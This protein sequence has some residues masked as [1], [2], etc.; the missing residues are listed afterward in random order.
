MAATRLAGATARAAGCD[1]KSIV[2]VSRV[3]QSITVSATCPARTIFTG[4]AGKK[5]ALVTI[6]IL[7][8]ASVCGTWMHLHGIQHIMAVS[9][10]I[11]GSVESHTRA[12]GLRP[13]LPVVK[14]R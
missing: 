8:A 10:R 7:R 9:A 13:Y 14:G 4:R 5:W 3:T 6:I 1:D 11:A 2:R 12:S